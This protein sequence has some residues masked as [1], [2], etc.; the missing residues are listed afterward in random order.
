MPKEDLREMYSDTLQSYNLWKNWFEFRMSL[1]SYMKRKENG[2]CLW[3]C[4]LHRWLCHTSSSVA[5]VFIDWAT[6]VQTASVISPD[7]EYFGGAPCSF[8]H[9][10]RHHSPTPVLGLWISLWLCLWL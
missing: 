8:L 9:P 5:L 1:R 10:V 3:K 2:R 4:R 6:E 7:N